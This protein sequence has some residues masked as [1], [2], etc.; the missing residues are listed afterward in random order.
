MIPCC[1][2]V[3]RGAACRLVAHGGGAQK[4]AERSNNGGAHVEELLAFNYLLEETLAFETFDVRKP[5]FV[6]QWCF[7][8]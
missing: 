8:I 3:M 4:F 1:S 7:G 5:K 6:N 2:G